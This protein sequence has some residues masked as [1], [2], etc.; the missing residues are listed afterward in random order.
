MKVCFWALNFVLLVH[1]SI[2]WQHRSVLIIVALKYNL[3]SGYDTSGFELSS[4]DSVGYLGS[5]VGP[6]KFENFSSFSI[7]YATVIFIGVALNLYIA[8]GNMVN[9]VNYLNLWMQS[10]FFIPLCLFWFLSTWSC[11]FQCIVFSLPLLSLF[12]VV[13][14]F[15]FQLLF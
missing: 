11:S 6:Y 15:L 14:S 8:L 3:K 9:N 7:K 13:L 1:V 5:F 4:Q 10:L 2:F 12:L